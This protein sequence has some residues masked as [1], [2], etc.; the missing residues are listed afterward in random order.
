MLRASGGSPGVLSGTLAESARAP[1]GHRQH[2]RVRCALRCA[3][4]FAVAPGTVLRMVRRVA[5]VLLGAGL[6]V[7]SAAPAAAA[8]E[9][10]ESLTVDLSLRKNGSLAVQETIVYDFGSRRAHGVFRDIPL[11]S[12]TSEIRSVK[13]TRNGVAE[14]VDF[15]NT[16]VW[17]RVRAGD[18]Q[19]NVSGRQTY[20]L[21]YVATDAVVPLVGEPG[22]V[23]LS[24]DAVGDGW[25]VPIAK[26]RVSLST[27][28]PFSEVT[29]VRGELY[30]TDPC[31]KVAPLSFATGKLVPGEG[32]TIFAP[33][34]PGHGLPVASEGPGQASS[35]G[36]GQGASGVPDGASGSASSGATESTGSESVSPPVFFTALFV[37][38]ALTV[39]AA[40]LMRRRPRP[41]P[42][43]FSPPRDLSPLCLG[44]AVYPGPVVAP[45]TLAGALLD[46][47]RRDVISVELSDLWGPRV[48]AKEGAVAALDPAETV[49][50]DTVLQ[51]GRGPVV[52]SEV[53]L[54]GRAEKFA[55]V[56]QLAAEV[57]PLV[58][59]GVPHLPRVLWAVSMIGWVYAAGFLSPFF[60]GLLTA[61]T[62]GIAVGVLPSSLL[63]PLRFSEEEM[64]FSSEVEGFKQ[65]LS[66]DAALLRNEY[67]ERTGYTP[68]ALAATMLP[69]AVV[70][71]VES[72]WLKAFPDVSAFAWDSTSGV[73]GLGQLGAPAVSSLVRAAAPVRPRSTGSSLA[74]DP[75]RRTGV[76]HGR[77][78]SSGRGFSGSRG[79][80]RTRGGMGRRG[81]GRG[82]GGGGSW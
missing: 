4:A 76:R 62:L 56:Q 20:V 49:L 43:R 66:T 53:M 68:E 31:R 19:V 72:D 37:G 78:F 42:V 77:G 40:L 25:E 3:L 46:L 9:R 27:V 54:V 5:L 70:L 51:G 12:N 11:Q 73:S 28:L 36:A 10:V 17:F 2:A 50:L 74:F 69:Y 34:K 14:P 63:I 23:A 75:T 58:R 7:T 32:V 80:S 60:G 6:L 18:P 33:L 15:E 48:S 81:G 39:V 65:F 30:D 82:G 57:T 35:A 55:Q 41:A 1:P 22:E 26:S 52:I 64:Q 45:Q 29:C 59:N 44:A 47:A 38:I 67:V 24:W 79:A 8:S 13:V 71:G 16:G 61:V 21:S